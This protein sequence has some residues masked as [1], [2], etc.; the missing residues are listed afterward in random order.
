MFKFSRPLYKLKPSLS[1]FAHTVIKSRDI[2]NTN[3]SRILN[4]MKNNELATRY[5]KRH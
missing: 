3:E 4:F 2:I 1:K 5:R